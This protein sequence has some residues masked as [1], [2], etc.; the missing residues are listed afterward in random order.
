MTVQIKSKPT[1]FVQLHQ[2]NGQPVAVNPL[3]VRYAYPSNDP[4]GTVLFVD[5]QQAIV[6]SETYSQVL[7]VLLLP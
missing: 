3:L 2:T 4:V 7:A 5:V 1:E 6:V